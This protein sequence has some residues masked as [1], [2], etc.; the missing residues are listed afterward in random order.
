MAHKAVEKVYFI[1]FTV[2]VSELTTV[3]TATLTVQTKR[4]EDN[5]EATA[6]VNMCKLATQTHVRID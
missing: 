3:K 4:L 2:I 5:E 1:K 6:D